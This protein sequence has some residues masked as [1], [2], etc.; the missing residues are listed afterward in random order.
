MTDVVCLG[1][2]VADVIARPVDELPHGA[3]ALMDEVSLYGGG[4]ALNTAT[5]LTR[6]GSSAAVVGKVGEDTFGN[7]LVE[8]LEER[9][10][11]ATGVL[12]DPDTPTAATVVL[13]DGDGERSFLHLP[14]A[15]GALRADEIPRDIVYGAG[16]LHVAGALV[17]PAL[18]GAPTGEL[19]EDARARGVRT[20]LDTVFDASGRWDRV[21]PSLPH[22][23]LL[24]VGAAEATGITGEDDPARAAAWLRDRGVREVAVKLGAY[25]CHVA[26]E[27]FEGHVPA[28]PVEAVDGTGAGDA[29]VAG[30]LHG[31]LS[32]WA[33]EDAARLGNAAGACAV[34]AVGATEG[35][36]DLEGTLAFAGEGEGPGEGPGEGEA[37]LAPTDMEGV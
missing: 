30:L 35:L 22:L 32:G 18:D 12:R 6:L 34:T 2:L 36:R 10:L 27:E 37:S 20:S 9:G 19:L 17:M 14:G 24:T 7:F 15:N 16:A 26:G 23:D 13:V 3:V 29:F 31:L 5:A 21:L 28:V 4:C 11:D 33:L 25:G 8:L 1:I